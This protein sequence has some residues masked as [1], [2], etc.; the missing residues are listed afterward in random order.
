MTTSRHLSRLAN[1]TSLTTLLVAASLVVLLPNGSQAAEAVKGG[2]PAVSVQGT[3]SAAAKANET[4]AAPAAA[5]RM[6]QLSGQSTADELRAKQQKLEADN[7]AIDA[8]MK[9]ARDKAGTAMDAATREMAIGVAGGTAAKAAGAAGFGTPAAQ[10]H[11]QHTQSGLFAGIA[12]LVAQ[13]D[14]LSRALVNLLAS[15]GDTLAKKQDALARESE[16]KTKRVQ[17]DQLDKQILD[18]LGTIRKSSQLEAQTAQERMKGLQDQSEARLKEQAQKAKEARDDGKGANLFGTIFGGQLIGTV[19]GKEIAGQV[20]NV[21]RAKAAEAQAVKTGIAI[22][23]AQHDDKTR[24]ISRLQAEVQ[25]TK[26]SKA[27]ELKAEMSALAAQRNK[28]NESIGAQS[29][30]LRKV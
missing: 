16:L 22:L 29:A 7:K 27:D 21:Q 20:D 14:D 17:L 15:T 10:G 3:E 11:A 25:K 18:Q 19:I 26:G 8:G 4:K 1:S 30:E 5:G 28:L 12:G 24:E 23:A 9:E 13:R 6:Q 2:G